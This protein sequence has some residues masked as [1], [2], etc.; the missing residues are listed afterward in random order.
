M[1]HAPGWPERQLQQPLFHHP[2]P[3]PQKLVF[4]ECQAD[5]LQSDGGQ[6]SFLLHRGH[7]HLQDVH[8]AVGGTGLRSTCWWYLRTQRADPLV[9]AVGMLVSAIFICLTFMAAK[10]SIVG[11]YTSYLIHQSTKDSLLWDFLS[12]GYAI[13]LCPFDVFLGGMFFL[14][15]ALFFLSNCAKAEQQCHQDNEE[16]TLPPSLEGVL[17]HPGPP[18]LLMGFLCDPWLGTYPL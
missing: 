14:A 15:M 6:L 10:S 5:Q 7:C 4:P 18:G 1:P 3:E 16:P 13:M 9:C 2:L 12:L 11:V 17:Q 8:Q